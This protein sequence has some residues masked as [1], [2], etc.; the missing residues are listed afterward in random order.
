MLPNILPPYHRSLNMHAE[1]IEEIRDHSTT[2]EVS[3]TIISQWV[4][5]PELQT[6]S[7]ASEWEDICSVEVEKW[8]AR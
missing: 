5:Q 1:L 2:F 4:E 7:W 3:R 8:N 6:G